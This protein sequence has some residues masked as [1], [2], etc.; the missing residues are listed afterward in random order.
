MGMGNWGM[1]LTFFSGFFGIKLQKMSYEIRPR[2]DGRGFDLISDSLPF[3]FPKLR[4]AVFRRTSWNG[5]TSLL[6]NH[7]YAM[8]GST[9]GRIN[10]GP[11]RTDHRWLFMLHWAAR[12]SNVLIPPAAT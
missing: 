9:R 2:K 8:P 6:R 4:S 5:S 11:L 12:A 7:N 10:D 3:F 1:P